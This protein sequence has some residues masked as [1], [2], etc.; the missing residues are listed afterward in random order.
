MKDAQADFGRKADVDPVR[1]LLGTAWGWGGL[2]E[3]EAYYI[4]VK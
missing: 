2:P 4:N 1:H 3:E